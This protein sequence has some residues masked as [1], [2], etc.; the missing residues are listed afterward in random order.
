[1]AQRERDREGER[2]TELENALGK[3]WL[4]GGCTEKEREEGKG[5]MVRFECDGFFVRGCVD[6]RDDG[7]M[8]GSGEWYWIGS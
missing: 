6:D 5:I 2:E 8:V 7:S 1:M 4:C 3:R